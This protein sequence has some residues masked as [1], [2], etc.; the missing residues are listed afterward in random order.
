MNILLTRC[1]FRTGNIAVRAVFRAL[2]CR[3]KTEQRVQV[4]EQQTAVAVKVGAFQT[5]YL[6]SDLRVL[7]DDA[8]QQ[9]SVCDRDLTAAVHISRRQAGNLCEIRIIGVFGGAVFPVYGGI[10]RVIRKIC[11]VCVIRCSRKYL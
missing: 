11:A 4:T 8:R 2:I 1:E 10:I 5:A 7:R 9:Y 6:R 3:Q